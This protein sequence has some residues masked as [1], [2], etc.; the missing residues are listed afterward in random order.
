MYGHYARTESL[1]SNFVSAH[2]PDDPNGN[3][4]QVRDDEDSGDEGDLKFEGDEAD[5]YR[6]TYFK[7]TNRSVDDWNDIINL[8]RVLN[9]SDSPDFVGK[10]SEVIDIDQ[11]LHFLAVD[12]L[13]GNREG[14]LTTGKGDDYALYR[15]EKRPALSVG[16]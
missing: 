14:G 10:I 11:W 7:K 1:D 9:D 15:G 13:V 2:W 4:Y 5:N 12:S 8:T 3:L 6:N 16:A